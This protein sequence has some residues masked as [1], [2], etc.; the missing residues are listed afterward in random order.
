[1]KSVTNNTL[2]TPVLPRELSVSPSN[3]IWQSENVNKQYPII[4]KNNQVLI[5]TAKQNYP[6]M[7]IS[8]GTLSGDM[9]ILFIGVPSNNSNMQYNGFKVELGKIKSKNAFGIKRIPKFPGI[10]KLT[11]GNV[12]RLKKS[13]NKLRKQAQ[14]SITSKKYQEFSKGITAASDKMEK[15]GL[16]LLSRG[17]NQQGEFLI[18]KAKQSRSIVNQYRFADRA[19]R[20]RRQ[21]TRD[22]QFGV[23]PTEG[24]TAELDITPKGAALFTAGTAGTY[25]LTKKGQ[26]FIKNMRA[27]RQLS[28]YQIKKY[29]EFAGQASKK[30]AEANK[31]IAKSVNTGNIV[32]GLGGGWTEP[33]KARQLRQEAS[34]L[35]K[36]AKSY[37][38]R[39][40]IGGKIKKLGSYLKKETPKRVGKNFL[41][42]GGFGSRDQGWGKLS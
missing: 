34:V 2:V 3:S 4:I 7:K 29:N 31:I 42:R 9:F 17:I 16:Q 13:A 5:R 18:Q 32:K 36:K 38:R 6:I 28:P 8:T 40:G 27:N 37:T 19:A 14:V 24:S 25:Y 15:R 20:A 30:I 33:F 26:K 23:G 22:F 12:K 10:T 11:S 21:Q 35:M 1:M 41:R 39:P